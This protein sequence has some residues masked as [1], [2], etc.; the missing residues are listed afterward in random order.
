M[1]IQLV[2]IYIGDIKK[3]N[4]THHQL[5]YSEMGHFEGLVIKGNFVYTLNAQLT[6]FFPALATYEL[7]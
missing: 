6:T 7:A 5:A 2:Y 1:G 4:I 3:L